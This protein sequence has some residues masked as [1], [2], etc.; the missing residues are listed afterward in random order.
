MTSSAIRAQAIVIAGEQQ[1][2]LVHAL[3]HAM[4]HALGNVERTVSYT[5]PVEANAIRTD[6]SRCAN[7]SADMQSGS[8][9]TL[10]ILGG[11]PVFA[12]PADLG[13]P[14]LS[15]KSSCVFI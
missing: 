6:S 8:V 7:W 2:P 3:A 13:S 5:E 4:N 1:P 9:D 14:T 11:N 10:V 12:A 15:R